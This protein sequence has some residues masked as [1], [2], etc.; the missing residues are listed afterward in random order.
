M[1][2]RENTA[3][4]RKKQTAPP[5]PVAEPERYFPSPHEG[6][7]REQVSLRRE[8][9]LW[10]RPV[11]SPS[12]TVGQIVRSN[13][14]TF[15]NLIFFILGACV[16]AVGSFKNLLFLLVVAANTLIGIIQ[17]IR[18]KRVLDRLT[19]L[20]APQAAVVREGEILTVGT[21]ELVLDDVVRFAPGNQICADAVV[22]EGAVQVNEA[23]VTGEARPVTR[24]PGDPLLSGSFVT[25]GTCAARLERVGADSYAARL[26]VEAKKDGRRRESGMMRSLTRLVQV[27]A[28]ILVPLGLALFWR[29]YVHLDRPFQEAVVS[30][31]A[32]LVG[33]IP[34]GLYLLTSVALAV[35]VIRL[36]R[37]H[38]LIH[39]LSGIETLARVDVLCVDK[40]GTITEN[41]MRAE[42]PELLPGAGFP[43]EEMARL[44]GMYVL[45]IGDDNPTAQALGKAFPADTLPREWAEARTI[46]FSSER[47]WSAVRLDDTLAYVLGA[48]DLLLRFLPEEKARP[49]E[50]RVKALSRA[51][52]R[53]VLLARH[54]GP[55]EGDTLSGTLEPLALIPLGN[56][57]R[58][59][60]AQT[61]AYFA[62]QG[63]QVKVI[64][65]DSPDTVSQVAAQAGIPG[66]ER[67]V[68]ASLLAGPQELEQAARDCTV[69]GRV[70]PEQKREL[71]R[72]LKKAG[73]TV[74]MTGDGVNDVLA[75]KE[76]DCGIAMASGSDAASQVAQVVLLDSDFAALPQVVGEGRRVINNI[77]RAASLF[78]VKTVFSLLFALVTLIAGLPYPVQ[79]LQLSLISALTIGA[80]AFFLALEPNHN[81][82][83]GRFLPKVLS[84]ALP[85][86]LTDLILLLGL[87]VFAAVFG[88]T[89]EEHSTMSAILLAEVGLLVLYQV[90]KPFNWKR[91]V[92]WTVMTAAMAGCILGFGEFF[93]MSPLSK[94][95]ALILVLFLL[96]AYSV[97]HGILWVVG[98][99]RQIRAWCRRR[100]EAVRRYFMEPPASV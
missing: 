85:G 30:T 63:V 36:A 87:Q 11:E 86:G 53:V 54:A 76:A 79:P 16:I 95:A 43:A 52:K 20:T 51:G 93:L 27:I 65:G 5:E 60:A 39:E 58:A 98:R 78:L 84:R 91:A 41:E 74:A 46:P 25:V 34:E 56:P 77:E 19:L 26:T 62:E 21:E 29:Q 96:L 80:P 48:P 61:F 99:Y 18:A 38:T 71:V 70:T 83:S 24:N 47:K 6:L 49:A 44:V 7:T 9:G 73:H 97:L 81:R 69:F 100:A 32:A 82:V 89:D 13:V 8:Q 55:M 3:A 1:A 88:F 42:P 66:V 35:G 64:S 31:V 23:L 94:E 15:F 14:F 68:N 4:K 33:M 28:V 2:R 12:K 72:A 10:N 57:L 59:T 75:L 45:R 17:E 67:A 92:I 22:L 90:C 50:N 37:R 40:T